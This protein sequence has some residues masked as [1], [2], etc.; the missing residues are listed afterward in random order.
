[1]CWGQLGRPGECGGHSESGDQAVTTSARL[2][3]SVSTWEWGLFKA[4]CNL[5]YVKWARN[6]YFQSK[7]N[8]FAIV[9]VNFMCHLDWVPRHLV[10]HYSVVLVRGFLGWDEIKW[11]DQYSWLPSSTWM[12]LIPLIKDLTRTKILNKREFFLLEWLSWTLMF[13][14]FW[15][16]TEKVALLGLRITDLKLELNSISISISGSQVF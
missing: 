6:P 1:M 11:I 2:C 8:T 7:W 5:N 13:L 10:K 14:S 16:Q 9:M 4:P 12:G 15:I 3:L